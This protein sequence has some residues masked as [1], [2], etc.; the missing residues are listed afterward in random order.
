MI[1]KMRHIIK[2]SPVFLLLVVNS[3]FSQSQNYQLDSIENWLNKGSKEERI[4]RITS[5]IRD[6][7]FHEMDHSRFIPYINDVYTWEEKNPNPKLLNT[8]RLGHVNLLLA[9]GNRTE[10]V[11]LLQEIL[12][13]KESVPVKDSVSI[14]TFLF[15]IYINVRSFSKAWEVLKIRDNIL[16]RTD[17]K[18]H[19]FDQFKKIRITNLGKI[20]YETKDYNN[21]IIQYKKIL[22]F[23][24][25]E[26]DLHFEAGALN[27]IG[28]TYLK[29]NK[30]DS[31]IVYFHQSIKKWKKHL[32][33]INSPSIRDSPF[34]NL[35]NGN[36]G[37]AYNDKNKY[38]TAIPL[39]INDIEMSHKIAN[40][41]GMVNGLSELSL[42]YLG[43]GRPKRALELL[44]SANNL[45]KA[46]QLISGYLEIC[47][48]K[49]KVYEYQ[50]NTYQ[51]YQLYKEFVAYKDS[52]E[53][54]GYANMN[55]ILQVEYEVEQKNKEIDNQKA[56]AIRAE[57]NT[58]IQKGK[59]QY[60][61]IVVLLML[62]VVIILIINSLQRKKRVKKLKE[63]SQQI[64]DQN[65]IIEK[66]LSDKETLLKEIHHRVKNNLQLISGILELQ[67]VQFN[68]KNVKTMMEEGQSRVRSMALIHQQ[69]YQSDD[70]E[71]I[72]FKEYLN[73]LTNDISI[74]FNDPEKEI[75]FQIKVEHFTLDINTAVPLGLI[76]NELIA[77]AYKHA[78]K[79]RKKG[80]ITIDLTPTKNEE[81]QLWINDD[82]IGLPKDFDPH[83]KK[84]LG[85][86]L[87]Q[88]LT[89]QLDGE[90]YFES[91]GGTKF[92]LQFKKVDILNIK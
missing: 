61:I 88:G 84:T 16:S 40:Y 69:L 81:I 11:R 52:I 71:K 51:A 48:N 58:E 33:E 37:Q 56:R 15:D 41:G 53:H 28:I 78:F 77:N 86:R 89:R 14:Y 18:S 43:L 23:A 2:L 39:L 19:F 12:H 54:I 44:D 68:D 9:E 70:L 13:S 73:K 42:S 21:A 63:K 80:C 74:A 55:A 49:I 32:V 17:I 46:N 31:A 10:A 83:S 76:V 27:N 64:K 60:L 20:Y 4:V 26:N 8:I 29:K 59:Q 47:E 5:F 75:E 90:Y 45:I 50:G 82:G 25:K 24:Q 87:V 34:L 79:G 38:Q 85:L 3:L 72:D 1:I 57:A 36:I 65:D 92:V 91:K 30:P 66:A 35:V 6:A 7:N 22:I 62:V 67:A